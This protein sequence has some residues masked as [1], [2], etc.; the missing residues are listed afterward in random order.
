IVGAGLSGID[1]AHHLRKKCPTKTLERSL[2]ILIPDAWY[3]AVTGSGHIRP[4]NAGSWIHDNHSSRIL[5]RPARPF[6]PRR[7]WKSNGNCWKCAG[8]GVLLGSLQRCLHLF[9]S[10]KHHLLIYRA[11]DGDRTRD[12]QLGKSVVD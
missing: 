3:N 7:K 8:G 1:A 12:V 4:G 5:E 9:I 6:R 10:H 11:G 2:T